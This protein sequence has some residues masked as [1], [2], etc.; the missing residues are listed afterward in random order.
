MLDY[1]LNYEVDWELLRVPPETTAKR[2]MR[3]ES[4]S[5]EDEWWRE[6]LEAA[7]EASWGQWQTRIARSV[8]VARYSEWFDDFKGRGNKKNASSLGAY[9]ARH[10]KAGGMP[11]WPKTGS[12]VQNNGKRENGCVFP[13]LAECRAVFDK[14]TGTEHD[15]PDD[16]AQTVHSPAA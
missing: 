3:A 16:E 2:E 15:W 11:S 1:F 4:L 7:D 8:V 12:K 6:V 9:F 10:F 14:A 13:S 5:S